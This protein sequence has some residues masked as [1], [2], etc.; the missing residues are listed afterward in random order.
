[1]EVLTERF[2]YRNITTLIIS[3]KYNQEKG[4]KGMDQYQAIVNTE[5]HLGKTL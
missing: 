1:M 4:N 3:K 5:G 2:E